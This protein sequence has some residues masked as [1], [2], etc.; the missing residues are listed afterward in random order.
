VFSS[1]SNL[2]F[3]AS[4]CGLNT[5]QYACEKCSKTYK[6]AKY[7]KEHQ[8]LHADPDVYQCAHC[9]KT[10]KSRSSLCKHTSKIH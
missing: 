10:Y 5:R 2:A 6:R 1:S 7:L 4:G 3:H 8:L 9:G